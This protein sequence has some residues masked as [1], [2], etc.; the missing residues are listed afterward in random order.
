M[1]GVLLALL[2]AAVY[3]AGDFV[4]GLAARRISVLF[5]VGIG[6]VAGLAAL[7]LLAL[8]LPAPGMRTADML[9]GA[10][11]G[12]STMVGITLLYQALATGRMSVAAPVT[13]LSA[14]S[15]PVLFAYAGGDWPGWMPTLGIALAAIAVALISREADRAG[16]ASGSARRALGL[17]L[18]A[19]LGIGVFYV[20]MK[21]THSDSGLWPLVAAR[22]S[23]TALFAIVALGMLAHIGRATLPAATLWAWAMLSGLLDSAANALYLLS[24][25]A[26]PLAVVATLTSLYPASTVVL[27][28]VLLHERLRPAQLAGLLVATVA[29]VLIVQG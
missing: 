27:A 23:S 25:R 16:I 9:W 11:S 6:Q 4:G 26:A 13:A 8:L 14:L 2:A 5:V 1:L 21:Q 28:R 22:A 7:L 24:S 15:L 17:A 12:V 20:T 29:V 3:G 19:G 18:A 10:A